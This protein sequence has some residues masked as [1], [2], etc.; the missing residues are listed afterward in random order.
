MFLDLVALEDGGRERLGILERVAS[1][2]DS[3]T[4]APAASSI[5]VARVLVRV[6]GSAVD[7]GS[8][9]LLEC[10][11]DLVALEDGRWE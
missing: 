8:E 1:R 7:V 6:G 10:L 9:E 5:G 11:F 4:C 2:L 3:S